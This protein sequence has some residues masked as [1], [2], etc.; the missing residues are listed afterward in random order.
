MRILIDLLN[1]VMG[2]IFSILLLP[3]RGLSPFWGILLVSVITALLM[4]WIFSKVSNQSAIRQIKNQIR[5]NLLG[6]RLFQHDVRVV[7]KVQSRILRLTLS[8]MRYSLIPMVVIILPVL[9]IIVQL[10][11]NFALSPLAPGQTTLVEL[12]TRDPFELDGD[13][14][15]ELPPGFEL[16]A[17]P[18]RQPPSGIVS[19]RIRTPAEEGTYLLTAGF[20]GESLQKELVVG[21]HWSPASPL[22]T[23]SILDLILY[24]GERSIPSSST[25]RS[26]SVQHQPLPISVLGWHVDWLILFFILSIALSFALKGLFGIEL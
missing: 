12:E 10:H 4:L 24:P 20:N 5:G 2:L 22:R 25:I 11:N 3:F 1:Q 21:N 15:L 7:L 6:V 23:S 17:P 16:E 8:Y 26:V 19:W 13:S 14:T 9:L 18:V